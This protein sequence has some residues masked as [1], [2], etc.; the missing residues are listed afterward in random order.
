[1]QFHPRFII[2]CHTFLSHFIS[3]FFEILIEIKSQIIEHFNHLGH[4]LVALVLVFILWLPTLAPTHWFWQYSI[5]TILTG[6]L[7]QLHRQLA[8]AD[9][10]LII[11]GDYTIRL[12][13]ELPADYPIR[14]KKRKKL[15]NNFFCRTGGVLG[16]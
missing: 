6:H 12:L 14:T 11:P 7:H 1:M 10:Y 13:S 9:N 2:F 16:D 4:W 8:A 5:S 15:S 3:F